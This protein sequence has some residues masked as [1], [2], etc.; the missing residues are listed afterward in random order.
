MRGDT[1][2]ILFV[3]L[4]WCP[5]IDEIKGRPLVNRA[6]GGRCHLRGRCAGLLRRIYGQS[7][8]HLPNWAD[9]IEENDNLPLGPLRLE[10]LGGIM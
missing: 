9:K 8:V 6:A 4:V 1:K 10:C 5:S 3:F 2:V 7:F